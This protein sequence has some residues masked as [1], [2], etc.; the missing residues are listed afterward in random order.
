ML[1]ETNEAFYSNI[2]TGQPLPRPPRPPRPPPPRPFVS[3]TSATPT[4]TI[5]S[6]TA[7]D[8]GAHNDRAWCCT[9]CTF[10]NHPYLHNCEQCEMPLLTSGT[11]AP[12]P[13][14]HSNIP[15]AIYNDYNSA[16]I[17]QQSM[18]PPNPRLQH[19][20]YQQSAP[21]IIQNPFQY[22]NIDGGASSVSTDSSANNVVINNTLPWLTQHTK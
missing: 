20:S 8:E 11:V 3:P 12:S 10:Q 19:M 14:Q 13:Q 7:Y 15:P 4:S 1:G 16:L 21:P 9:M 18:Q 2:Y 17:R 22:T 5:H 6:S